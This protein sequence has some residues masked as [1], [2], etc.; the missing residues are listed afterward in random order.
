VCVKFTTKQENQTVIK[1]VDMIFEILKRQMVLNMAFASEQWSGQ[2]SN[3]PSTVQ[4]LHSAFPV[5]ASCI[6][7]TVMEM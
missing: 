5:K 4:L 3:L 1:M 2:K 7:I 6:F